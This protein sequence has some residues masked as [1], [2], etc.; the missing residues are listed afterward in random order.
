MSKPKKIPH[1]ALNR[2]LA[3]QAPYT[4]S[5]KSIRSYFLK[6]S[7]EDRER[8]YCLVADVARIMAW[9]AGRRSWAEL[10][11]VSTR[12]DGEEFGVSVRRMGL[13]ESL[14]T[15]L[16][17]IMRK[18]NNAMQLNAMGLVLV[19][20]QLG[21]A[22][23]HT[24]VMD[25]KNIAGAFIEEAF[26]KAE[27]PV[28][29]VADLSASDFVFDDWTVGGELFTKLEGTVFTP[30][31]DNESVLT[32][33]N[34]F[35]D[36][37]RQAFEVDDWLPDGRGH[38]PSFDP[39]LR[40]TRETGVKGVYCE[41]EKLFGT[42]VAADTL[43]QHGY[44]V[45][46]WKLVE[47]TTMMNAALK[48]WGDQFS[49]RVRVLIGDAP[50]SELL[51]RC[52]TAFAFGRAITPAFILLAMAAEKRWELLAGQSGPSN[53]R[54]LKAMLDHGGSWPSILPPEGVGVASIYKSK[55]PTQKEVDARNRWTGR[56][57]NLYLALALLAF[58]FWGWYVSLD[59]NVNFFGMSH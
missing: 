45:D 25:Q 59:Q 57:I 33:N 54:Q 55:E 18:T 29:E 53:S 32:E 56:E 7:M 26:Q 9:G 17:L 49:G 15:S 52:Y 4:K 21:V 16:W 8:F 36:T 22:W 40:N 48:L 23:A 2:E 58:M 13:C 3:H 5:L 42:E 20:L 35:N 46:D 41:L 47:Q 51:N 50:T 37:L 12:Y 43:A 14:A 44:K 31:M 19:R 24:R 6:L 11:E 38:S 1:F 28:D 34:A 10:M 30:D 39:G 27:I